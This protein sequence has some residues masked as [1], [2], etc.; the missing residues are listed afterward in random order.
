[1]SVKFVSNVEN[2]DGVIAVQEQEAVAARKKCMD[3]LAAARGLW[4]THH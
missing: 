4:V 1:M 3:G 2:V